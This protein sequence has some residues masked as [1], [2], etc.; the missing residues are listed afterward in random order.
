MGADCLF[1]S[2]VS[3]S[4]LCAGES[5][6]FCDQFSGIFCTDFDADYL[7]CGFGLSHEPGL[8]YRGELVQSGFSFSFQEESASSDSG[9][10]RH[11]G[12]FTFF[13]VPGKRFGFDADSGVK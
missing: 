2:G 8:Q 9:D 6:L 11:G 10:F 4:C 7:W 3:D 12:K 5:L 13:V 1:G